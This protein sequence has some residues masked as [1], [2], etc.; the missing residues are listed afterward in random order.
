MSGKELK[1]PVQH[2]L[3]TADFEADKKLPVVGNVSDKFIIYETDLLSQCEKVHL[4]REIA[5]K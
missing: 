2:C 4:E 3:L 1:V 5:Q